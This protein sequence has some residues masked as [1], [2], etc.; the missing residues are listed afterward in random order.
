M[1][2]RGTHE[3]VSAHLKFKEIL[4]NPG[5]LHCYVTQ[6]FRQFLKPLGDPLHS[7]FRIKTLHE[8]I[9]ILNIDKGVK[10][11]ACIFFLGPYIE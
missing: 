6:Y 8:I 2:V 5:T 9:I 7:F 3:T 11:K 1:H 4:F 10:D